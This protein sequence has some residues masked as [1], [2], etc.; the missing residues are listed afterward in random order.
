MQHL[1]DNAAARRLIEIGEGLGVERGV[2][3]FSL[4]QTL[5]PR[6]RSARLWAQTERFHAHLAAGRWEDAIKGADGL[7]RYLDVPVPGLWRD[8]LLPD[9]SFVDEPAPGSSLYHIVSAVS[10]LDAACRK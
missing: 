10:A 2:A 1:G 7:Q 4:D 9:G 5:A 6:D 3:F 8:R